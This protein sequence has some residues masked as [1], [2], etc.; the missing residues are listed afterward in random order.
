MRVIE[1]HKMISWRG[2]VKR[3]TSTLHCVCMK[4]TLQ[5]RWAV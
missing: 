1:E 3:W 4:N 5:R 2:I